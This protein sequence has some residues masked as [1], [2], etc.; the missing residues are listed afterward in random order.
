MYRAMVGAIGSSSP[1]AS[2]ARAMAAGQDRMAV[3][4]QKLATELSP[5]AM[6]DLALGKT[7]VRVGTVLARTADDM[8]GTLIDELA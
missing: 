3:A 5:E 4:A 7:Q 6:V 1:F 8:T 2:A